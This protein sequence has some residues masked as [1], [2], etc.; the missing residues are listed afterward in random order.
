MVSVLCLTGCTS[1]EIE[2]SDGATGASPS[3]VSAPSQT[4]AAARK[5]NWNC[6]R[7]ERAVA[8][9]FDASQSAKARAEREEEQLPQTM[10]RMIARLS[11]PPGAGN[12]ALADFEETRRQADELNHLLREKGCA[13]YEID[14]GEP[15]FLQK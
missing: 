9:L 15:A 3:T 11:G 8:N 7:I 1:A 4:A 13:T 12:A 5:Q 6:R 2:S 14:A 10:A